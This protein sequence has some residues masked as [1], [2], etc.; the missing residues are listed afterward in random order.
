VQRTRS[1]NRRLPMQLAVLIPLAFLWGC[2]PKN[3]STVPTPPQIQA[4]NSVN[5]LAQSLDSAT[6]A[7]IAARDNGTMAQA[8]VTIAFSVIKVLSATGKQVNA[9]L[10]S[11]DTWDVQKGKILK[12]IA[13]SGLT[14][15]SKRLPQNARLILV[16]SLTAFNSISSGVGGPTL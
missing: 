5:V 15:L 7:I 4:A 1:S 12:I 9:E 2:P 11:P 6:S 13:N 14:E 3:P 16:A 8:D 10:I